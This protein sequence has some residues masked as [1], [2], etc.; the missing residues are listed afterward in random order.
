[1]KIIELFFGLVFLAA[2]FTAQA[3]G[4]D[5]AEWIDSNLN[6]SRVEKAY[7]AIDLAE[8]PLLMSAFMKR[9]QSS[10]LIKKTLSDSGFELIGAYG[11]YIAFKRNIVHATSEQ[12]AGG[13]ANSPE[14]FKDD[15][16]ADV[17]AT[18]YVDATIARGNVVRVYDE[19]IT[20]G[21]HQY[22]YCGSFYDVVQSNYLHSKALVE[23]TKKGEVVSF[24]GR[25][26]KFYEATGNLDEYVSIYFVGMA[27]TFTE[28]FPA[29]HLKRHFLRE[30]S[31]PLK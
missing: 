15:S 11:A 23:Y 14:N 10:V 31:T 24:L 1:M 8:D 7:K 2:T 3:N 17:L 27:K 28:L 16:D 18:M 13:I 19:T 22:F 26:Q 30:I 5:S 9:A 29:P 20:E 6:Q 4:K 21:I 25:G 12:K